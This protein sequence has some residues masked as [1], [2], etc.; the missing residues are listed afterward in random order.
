MWTKQDYAY[1]QQA[2]ELAQ[3]GWGTTWPNPLVGAVVVKAGRVVGTGW[4]RRAGEAHA[5]VLAL[6]R[7]GRAAR[8]ATLYLNLEPCSHQGRT[9]PCAP[10]VVR[11]GVKRVVAAMQDPNPKVSGRGFACLKRSG[12]KVEVGLMRAE[13]L[14]LNE[15]FIKR[16]TTGLP[17]VLAKAALTLDGKI[18]CASGASRW[19]TALPARRYAHRLRSLADA[20]V[21]GAGTLRAD[22]PALTVRLAPVLRPG[23]PWRIVLAGK[24]GVDRGAK[25]FRP[26]AAG[27]KTIL[28]TGQAKHRVAPLPGVDLWRLPGPGGRVDLGSLLRKLGAAACS[29]VLVE[30]GAETL[31]AFLGLGPGGGRN[32]VDRVHFIYAPKLFGGRHAPGAIGGAGVT[33]PDQALRLEGISWE[34]L[35]PD[36]LLKATPVAARPKRPGR[37]A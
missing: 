1:M 16:I 11:A 5:E 27:L 34:T 20:V 7:A 31:A 35:G 4:H 3:K 15:V 8:G 25:I 36:I 14:R 21:V 2:L 29:L 12:V 33:G 28:A 18:A 19:I 9:P 13:A 17:F 26:G 30:G 22:D 23:R 6:R 10:L 24:R 37:K 32:W